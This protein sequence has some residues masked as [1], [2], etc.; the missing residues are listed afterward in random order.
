MLFSTIASLTIFFILFNFS[1]LSDSP[2]KTLTLEAPLRARG[3]ILDK[4][5]EIKDFALPQF[6]RLAKGD[7]RLPISENKPAGPSKISLAAQF[8]AAGQNCVALDAVSSKI[9]FEKNAEEPRPVASITKLMTALVFLEHNPG[10]E[11]VY[12]IKAEDKRE[13]GKFYLFTGESVKVKDLFYSSLIASDN[14]ATIALVKSTGMSEEEFVRIMNEKAAELSLKNTSFSDPI[15]LSNANISTPRE[16]AEFAKA[17]L[18]DKNIS[19][20]TLTKKYE[21]STGEGRKKIVRNTDD[22]LDLFPQ[23]G[24]RIAGGK[25]GYTEAAG[26]CFVGKF[27]DHFGNEI[28]SVVLR[29]ESNEYRFKEIYDLVHWAYKNY[30]WK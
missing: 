22:L 24:I 29:E 18:A 30:E 23:N 16:V 5:E 13:G 4:I 17:A 8:A 7:E 14:I 28:I 19:E 15:G 10:W 9:L 26:Y 27:V 11:L 3:E 2:L 1:Y 6:T 21:F 25:T 20:A 12:K